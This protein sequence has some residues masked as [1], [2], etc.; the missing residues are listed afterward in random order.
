MRAAVVEKIGLLNVRDVLEPEMGEYDALCEIL[1]GATC[2]GTD[3]HLMDGKHPRPVSF[4]TVLGH[5]SIGRV[6]KVGSKVTSYKVGDLVTRV[7]CPAS[8]KGGYSSNWGGFCEYGIAKDHAQ[9]QKD[10][11]P[12]AQWFKSR[13]NMVIPEGIDPAAATMI[14]TWRE[15]YS[16]IHRMCNSAGR[17]SILILGSGSNA[18]AFAVHAHNMGYEHIVVVGSNKRR[19][20][21]EEAAKAVYIDYKT[22]DLPAAVKESAPDGF[23]VILDAI[24]KA[25]M[26]DSLAANIRPNGVMGIYGWDDYFTNSIRPMMIPCSFRFYNGGY[27]ENE[28]H[29]AVVQQI[30]SGK[31]DCKYW[32]DCANP[33]PLE[34]IVQAYEDVRGRKCLKALI[35]IK[36]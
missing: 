3:Q 6:I 8:E 17:E 35:Q 19:S 10:G 18:L 22:A 7:G 13:V 15:T 4:P 36:R 9:M 27:D 2:A 28:A 32:I 14:I 20:E 29:E 23:D 31:L 16:Y 1:Y 11:C 5:E 33:Y 21:F 26:L 24:G 30:L 25:G 12:K 34:E